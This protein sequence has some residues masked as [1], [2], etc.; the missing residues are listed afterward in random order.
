MNNNKTEKM[1]LKEEL[2]KD[3]LIKKL[4]KLRKIDVK[5]M[6]TLFI[7][8]I[9]SFIYLNYQHQQI[10]YLKMQM[11]DQY[12][13]IYE[14]NTMQTYNENRQKL[15]KTL[16]RKVALK[17]NPNLSPKELSDLSNIFYEVGELQ[18]DIKLEIWMVL[19]ATESEFYPKAKSKAGAIGI[20]QVMPFMGRL[21]AKQMG[22]DWNGT[23]TLENYMN[24]AKI[25]MRI[26]FDLKNEFDNNPLYYITAYNWGETA[27]RKFIE[28][29]MM[30]NKKV[31]EYYK[32]FL[33][34]KKQI[35]KIIG[36]KIIIENLKE[37]Q[38]GGEHN[39]FSKK[40]IR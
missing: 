32:R 36:Y 26:F 31:L 27:T 9:F 10:Y 38:I 37:E 29:G 16:F 7:F 21:Y 40:I 17:F 20:L 11:A 13:M 28:K 19:I 33:K 35:E 4:S 34:M 18:Y 5:T 3:F 15:V 2:T 14:M 22:I 30:N 39:G 1:L 24:N 8:I 12:S 6:I 23:S 25:G